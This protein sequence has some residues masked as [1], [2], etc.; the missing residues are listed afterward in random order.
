MTTRYVPS[1][2]DGWITFVA[3][4]RALLLGGQPDAATIESAWASLGDGAAALLELLTSSGLQATPPFALVEPM[5]SG[6]RVIVRGDVEVAVGSELLSG[7]G[8][9]TWIERVV[10]T[11]G[12]RARVMGASDDAPALP[13]TQGVVHA[14]SVMVEAGAAHA[15]AAPVPA[16]A[17]AAPVVEAAAAVPVVEV[18]AAVPVVEV[19]ASVPPGEVPPAVL[20]P[21]QTLG[22][23]S[24]TGSDRST[25]DL[26]P[27]SPVELAPT[28][29]GGGD[30]DYDYLFGATMYRSVADA[31]IRDDADEAEPEGGASAVDGDHDGA[32]VLVSSLPRS[33]T[34]QH[35]ASSESA[36][37]APPQATVVVLLPNG[38]REVL[39]EPL[40]LGRAPSVAG[41][42]GRQVPRLVTLAGGDH[43]IS[44]SHLRVE[45]EGDTVVVTDLNSKNGTRVTLPGG[46]PVRLRPGEPTPVIVGTV[47]DVGGV[48]E[49]TVEND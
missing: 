44:R 35:A 23:P 8:A 3:D 1:F 19:S 41:V 31:A 7:A 6:V 15:V 4:D 38:A 2:P 39:D 5:G 20:E 26:A 18:P 45:L 25:V 13:L 34:R 43:D 24:L 47:V 49:L 22:V 42:P 28:P 16:V 33:R 37:A 29:D 12:V 30:S 46:A 40:V 14:S 9:A 10:A 32:T 11:G 21:E 27:A 36:S 48:V 17:A